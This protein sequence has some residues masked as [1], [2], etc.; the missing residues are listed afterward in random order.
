MEQLHLLTDMEK[1]YIVLD[2]SQVSTELNANVLGSRLGFS[3]LEMDKDVYDLFVRDIKH[4]VIDRDTAVKGNRYWAETRERKSAY[5]TDDAGFTIKT[6]VSVSEESL[7]FAVKLMKLYADLVIKKEIDRQF[8][9]IK[10]RYSDFET[11]TWT[12]QVDEATKYLADNSYEPTILKSLAN[13][14]E[15]SV[16]DLANKVLS[17]SQEYKAE[18]AEILTVQQVVGKIFENAS[19]I[20]ALNRLYEEYLGIEMPLP[21]AIEDGLTDENGKRTSVSKYGLNLHL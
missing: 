2:L 17:K 12:L 19:D 10:N 18:I 5:D 7:S 9:S 4:V 3:T 16:E 13:Q 21:Q 6:Y 15:I 1:I 8:Q 14:R 20:R 11:T